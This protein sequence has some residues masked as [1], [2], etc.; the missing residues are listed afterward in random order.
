MWAEGG[1]PWCGLGPCKD[2]CVCVGGWVW[3]LVCVHT[4]V[5]DVCMY[6]VLSGA[7]DTPVH[8]FNYVFLQHNFKW[9]TVAT[10]LCSKLIR[11]GRE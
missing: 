3:V 11:G 8:K 5:C 7:V 10:Y 1:A 9:P 6:A 4:C 2:V